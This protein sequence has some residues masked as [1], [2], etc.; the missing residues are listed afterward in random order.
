MRAS[1]AVVEICAESPP[2]SWCGAASA[3][4]GARPKVPPQVRASRGEGRRAE[5]RAWRCQAAAA[6]EIGAGQTRAALER[7]LLWDSGRWPSPEGLLT[8]AVLAILAGPDAEPEE[9]LQRPGVAEDGLCESAG[10]TG[11]VRKNVPL[12]GGFPQRRID[13][14]SSGVSHPS[15]DLSVYRS[16]DLYF[17]LC[18]CTC[19]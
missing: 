13:D 1:A 11:H 3:A 15:I 7:A 19:I 18:T 17:H 5:G 6:R 12:I 2:P 16:I 10:R 14:R 8:E 9:V 4:V